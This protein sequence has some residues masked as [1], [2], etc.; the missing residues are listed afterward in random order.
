[1]IDKRTLDADIIMKG[2]VTSGIVYPGALARIAQDYRLRNI[3]GTSAGAI[4]ASA[5]AA[6][7]FGLRTGRNPLAQQQMEWLSREAGKPT[8][9]NRSFL[10]ALFEADPETL[11]IQQVLL[12]GRHGRL[13]PALRLFGPF[14]GG[15]L[16]ALLL[17]GI[18]VALALAL[19]PLA[20]SPAAS[21]AGLVTGLV[22]GLLTIDIAPRL[23]IDR[24]SRAL[25]G[26]GLGLMTGMATSGATVEG[27]PVPG[28]TQWLHEVIQSLAGLDAKKPEDVLTFGDLWTLDPTREPSA[29][30]ARREI[31]LVLVTSDLNRLQSVS[32]PFLPDNHRLFYDPRE[33]NRMFP[34]AV[35]AAMAPKAWQ[36]AEDDMPEKLGYA[37]EHVRKAA[38]AHGDLA[39]HL[40]LLP[41]AK[42][43]PI[44]I[45]ARASMAFPG[46][47][48]PLPMW[49]LRWV[50]KPKEPNERRAV[51]SRLYLSDGGITSNFPIH[52]FD[53]AA[54]NRPTFAFNLLYPGDDLSIEEVVDSHQAARPGKDTPAN[55]RTL[56]GTKAPEMEARLDDLIMPFRN[57][58][59][60]QFYKAPSD[61]RPV[62]RLID[63]GLR[64]VET[65]R[66]WGDVGLYNQIGMRDRIVHIRL[67]G[68]EGGFNLDM[69][70]DT[71]ERID[72][73]GVMAGTVL[74][75][76][77]HPAA[78][79]DPL[80]GGVAPELDWNNHRQ[81]R[82]TGILA[83][84]DLLATR[85]RTNWTAPEVTPQ[86]NV[87]YDS[88]V[89]STYFRA[90]AE[91]FSAIGALAVPPEDPLQQVRRPFGLSRIRPAGSDPRS[92]RR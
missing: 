81:M 61:G 29:T 60:V 11:A 90:V 87:P 91:G 53:S 13:W 56:G 2:G 74:A 4:A 10:H 89:H 65:A 71:I 37:A 49:L 30:D 86:R 32:F 42:N 24:I 73:K 8:S 48:T 7:E 88:L 14:L 16:A 67:T 39:N 80:Q 52:L 18:A 78:P 64:V 83:A 50:G 26:N 55:V 44:L 66:T 6:M 79:S 21:L 62:A 58:D 5:A 70:T 19:G 28:L 20:L 27:A 63:L 22:F 69:D 51:L 92:I 82:L 68:A 40:R 12:P 72:A 34:P 75:C 46:L 84:V 17:A 41:K 36:V 1:L 77:F 38:A 31:D 76:R 3:G 54:P 15:W 23:L 57:D 85:F 25:V 59:W 45:G 35:M 33:W 47:L 43:L 9:R